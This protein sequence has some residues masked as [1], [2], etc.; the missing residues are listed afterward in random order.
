[1]VTVVGGTAPLWLGIL[2]S[3]V[4]SSWQGWGPFWKHGELYLYSTALY[5]QAIYMLFE[6]K[7][8]SYDPWAILCWISILFLMCCSFLYAAAATSFNVFPSSGVTVNTS[9]LFG[10][11]LFAFVFSLFVFYISSYVDKEKEFDIA[12]EEREGIERVKSDLK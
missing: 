4:W 7:K 6:Q 1:V 9:F 2:L 12:T 10:T 11:S 8:K 3:L 5:I